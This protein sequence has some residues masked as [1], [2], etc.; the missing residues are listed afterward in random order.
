[1]NPKRD[2]VPYMFSVDMGVNTSLSLGKIRKRIRTANPAYKPHSLY[3][4]RLLHKR[5][6][7]LARLGIVR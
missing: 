5:A 1:M 7:R 3:C 4:A 2:I 6:A